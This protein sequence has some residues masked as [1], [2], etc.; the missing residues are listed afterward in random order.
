MRSG[1]VHVIGAG[2]AGLAAALD[3]SEAGVRVTLHEGSPKAGGRCR[4]YHDA[5]LDRRIDNGNHLI[6]SGNAAVLSHARRIGAADR[7]E[8][9][10]EAAFPFAD[11]ADGRRWTVRVPRTPLG[12]LRPDA[13]P[14]ERRPGWRKAADGIACA[15]G[16]LARR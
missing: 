14:P 7:L 6:L 11:L 5:V 9:L 15:A 3:L 13:R 2:L 10:P 4:S 12:S 16:S 8:A 1:H